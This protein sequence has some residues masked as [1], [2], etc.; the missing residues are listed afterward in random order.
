[1]SAYKCSGLNAVVSIPPV[2]APASAGIKKRRM[3]KSDRISKRSEKLTQARLFDRSLSLIRKRIGKARYASFIVVLARVLT[4]LY[5]EHDATDEALVLYAFGLIDKTHWAR[6]A[7]LHST[8]LLRTISAQCAKERLE[9]GLR[10]LAPTA[11]AEARDTLKRV[12]PAI[13]AMLSR[14]DGRSAALDSAPTQ[15]P[16]R[17]L[18]GPFMDSPPQFFF[19]FWLGLRK[20]PQFAAIYNTLVLLPP[21]VQAGPEAN[22]VRPLSEGGEA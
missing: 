4:G 7:D 12:V 15:E 13:Y 19:L 14:D 1:M 5:E 16:L 20:H 6:G 17:T 22:A 3:E 2:M 9:R 10:D 18:A 8:D 11:L 21:Q